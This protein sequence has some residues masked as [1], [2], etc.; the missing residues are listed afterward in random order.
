MTDTAPAH[1][2][3]LDDAAAA[4]PAEPSIPEPSGVTPRDVTSGITTMA[5]IARVTGA[6]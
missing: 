1:L 5:E 4:T 6:G 3:A 2:R